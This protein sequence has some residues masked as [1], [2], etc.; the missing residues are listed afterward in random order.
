MEQIESI[1]ISNEFSANRI[2]EAYSLMHGPLN[3]M[4]DVT[5]KCNLA[6]KHCYNRSG[7][8][9]M[10][11]DLDD[12]EMLNVASGIIAL[13]PKIV[14]FCGGEPL[15][16]Y[17]L[18]PKL[19]Q[20][21]ADAGIKVNMVTNGL[22]L[23]EQKI[24]T[25]Q[26]SGVSGFQI[27]L[28]SFVEDT[29]DYFRGYSGANAGA[30]RAIDLLLS[31]EIIPDVAFIPTRINY[32]DIEGVVEIL[33]FRGIRRLGTM[34]FIPIGRG[35]ENH[36][37]LILHDNELLEFYYLLEKLRMV[38]PDFLIEHEDPIEHITLFINNT[39]ARNVLIEIRSNGDVLI[40]SYLPFIFGNVR[41]KG[42]DELWD[43]GLK[44]IWRDENV[45][46]V[47][48]EIRSIDDLMRLTHQPWNKEDID[49]YSKIKTTQSTKEGLLE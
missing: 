12:S 25:L 16:R 49:L 47:A 46:T 15:L 42:L 34:P 38:Y 9:R 23:D 3:I 5:N 2:Q 31:K 43:L 28:D 17:N 7:I 18:L 8:G 10:Y 37:E 13:S 44:D 20:K 22:L 40:S 4:W 11:S 19:A 48:K 35:R 41:N 26:S 14:C 6:C 21:L 36:K 45:R 1:S 29:H 24:D 33:Y 27:S 30:I 39:M 32:K